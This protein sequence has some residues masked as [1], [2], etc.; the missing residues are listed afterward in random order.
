MKTY[1]VYLNRY[2]V[3]TIQSDS[4]ANAVALIPSGVRFDAVT[5]VYQPEPRTAGEMVDD[6]IDAAKRA[7]PTVRQKLSNIFGNLSKITAPVAK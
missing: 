6:T 4:I 5:T 2:L 3:T 1:Y 7:V